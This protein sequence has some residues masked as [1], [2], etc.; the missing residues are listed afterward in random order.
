MKALLQR[1]T[2]R[3]QASEGC[4]IRIIFSVFLLFVSSAPAAITSFYAFGDG[5]STTT[6]NTDPAV[7]Y[8]YYGHRFCNGRVWLEVL[9]QRQ[10]IAYN[11]NK[12]WSY[13]GHY[14][15]DLITNLNR[16]PA[17]ADANTSLFMLWV[18][19]AD[20]VYNLNTIDPP[21]TSSSLPAWNSLINQSLNNHRQAIQILYSKGARRLI[22]PNGV[23]ISKVP[24]YAYLS[25]SD[26]AFVRQRVLDFNSGYTST[27][28]Q[29][30]ASYP[31][32]ALYRPDFFGL[33][34]KM[35][36]RPVDYGFTRTDIDA[37]DD[38]ALA[39][40]SLNGPGSNYLFWDY[41]HPTA[42]AQM[43]LAD[44]VQQMVSPA[45]IANITALG[46]I[47]RLDLA[48]VPVGRNGLVQSSGNLLTWTNVQGFP[49]T[50]ITQTLFANSSGP[51]QF[52]RLS[53][54]FAWVWP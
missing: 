21:Y 17:P 24:Y 18:S 8:L 14:S 53:F 3:C 51:K 33:F 29:A 44:I 1:G 43:I 49:S 25:A 37:I 36:A 38:P 13:F 15:S 41:M 6:N 45:R 34:D 26:K 30:A 20:F 52:Y 35:V 46:S 50:N 22:V 39:D 19:D 42:K 2:G 5:V 28:D 9:S 54:P 16:F 27:L 10:G 40:K 32:L 31:D 11:A 23:D 48:N 47:Y 7:A 12:N 4:I